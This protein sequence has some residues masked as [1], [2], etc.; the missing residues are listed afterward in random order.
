M[1]FREAYSQ[2]LNGPW[3]MDMTKTTEWSLRV[4][5]GVSILV[6][7]PTPNKV[8]WFEN[9]AFLKIPY[10][11][12]VQEWGVHA[13]FLFK[14]KQVEDDVLE[15][16]KGIPSL[17]IVG[18]SEG[19]ALALLA[20]EDI[21]YQYPKMAIETVTFGCPRVVGWGAPSYL[22]KGLTRVVY[23]NDIVTHVPF[24]ALGFKHVGVKVSV[25]PRRFIPSVEDH[26]QYSMLT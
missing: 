12:M 4:V 17:T 11:D 1:D 21:G 8:S 24:A 22:W 9:F 2:T 19:A 25:G 5:N 13:G 6:F 15:A 14:W 18:Y 16:V 3:I 23:G 7:P 20:H 10:K 26:S